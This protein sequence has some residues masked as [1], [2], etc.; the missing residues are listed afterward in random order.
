[1]EVNRGYQ[2]QSRMQILGHM[3]KDQQKGKKL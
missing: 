3:Q 2:S 1:M